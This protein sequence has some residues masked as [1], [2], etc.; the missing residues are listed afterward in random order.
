MANLEMKYVDKSKKK[1]A[2]TPAPIVPTTT[3]GLDPSDLVSSI[4]GKTMI[5]QKANV[6]YQHINLLN[7]RDWFVEDRNLI[8]NQVDTDNP[9]ILTFNTNERAN[10]AEERFTLLKNGGV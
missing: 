4:P 1:T 9:I 6:L 2:P 7:V 8:V 3:V 10:R 5:V